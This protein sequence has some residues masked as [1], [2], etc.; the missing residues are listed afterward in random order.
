MASTAAKL[1]KTTKAGK[2]NKMH[3]LADGIGIPKPLLQK[4]EEKGIALP[5]PVKIALGFAH[6]LACTD[7]GDIYVWG[8]GRDG[9]LGLGTNR[10]KATPTLMEDTFG[11]GKRVHNVSAGSKH[12]MVIV[13][14]GGDDAGE[15]FSWGIGSNGRLG[16]PNPELGVEGK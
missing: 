11:S 4:T 2:A 6:S 13:V 12:T 15:L 1:P 9:Q 5:P 7:G 10:D 3:D 16:Y 8:L 14:D